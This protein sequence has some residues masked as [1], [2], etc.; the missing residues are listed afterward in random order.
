MEL[1]GQNDI[2]YLCDLN[3]CLLLLLFVYSLISELK[4]E[5]IMKSWRIGSL[6]VLA[7]FALLIFPNL[8]N[9]VTTTLWS[10][11][12]DSCPDYLASGTWNLASGCGLGENGT[13]GHACSTGGPNN[14][15]RLDSSGQN[16][17][18]APGKGFRVSVGDG[19]NNDSTRPYMSL[20]GSY[21]ELWI[22]WYMR[23]ALG[24]AWSGG[25]PLYQKLIYLNPVVGGNTRPYSYVGFA[26]NGFGI[27]TGSANYMIP[28]GW[29][30][31][32]GG[33]T[34]DGQ[35]HSYEAHVK[36]DTNGSNGIFEGWI[37]GVKRGALTNVNYGTTVWTGIVEFMT[38]QSNVANGQCMF[39]DWDDIV[40]SNTGYIGPLGGTAVGPA[41]PTYLH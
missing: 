38:N 6:F 41:P 9:A 7:V 15:S 40:I 17:S 4:G 18:S 16:P 19:V 10:S 1:S 30:S 13:D 5:Y 26:G 24:F 11:N 33:A 36:M 27:E 39:V 14:Y 32:M 2:D 23:Y 28:Y 37:D 21:T 12:F 25:A 34:S 31:I 22:R 35:W 3:H 29:N 8:S 20:S